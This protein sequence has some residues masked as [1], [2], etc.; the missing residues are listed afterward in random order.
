M[1]TAERWQVDMPDLGTFHCSNELY[2][3]IHALSEAALRS[4][5]VNGLQSDCPHRERFGYGGDVLAS[6]EA[7]LLMFDM[8]AMYRQRV[9]DYTLD[10]RANGGYTETGPFLGIDD[11]GLGGGSGPIEWGC[12]LRAHMS[13]RLHTCHLLCLR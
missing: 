9:E 8:H 11:N 2:N 5:F 4:N 1:I 13:P 10:Q 3:S 6:A 7:A 12:A